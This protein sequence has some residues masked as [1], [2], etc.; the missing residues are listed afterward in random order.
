[1]AIDRGR[2]A[3]RVPV[4]L[5]AFERGNGGVM[6]TAGKGPEIGNRGQ[7]EFGVEGDGPHKL[8]LGAIELTIATA[9]VALERIQPGTFFRWGKMFLRQRA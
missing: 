9:E 3:R 7:I 8:L 2:E 5:E 1:M 4:S 6:G